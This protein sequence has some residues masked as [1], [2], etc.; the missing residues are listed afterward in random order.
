M[1]T[2]LKGFISPCALLLFG[3]L[4]CFCGPRSTAQQNKPVPV[5]IEKKDAT[6]LKGKLLGIA[7]DSVRLIDE[8]GQEWKISLKDIRNIEYQDSVRTKK[9]WFEAPNTQRYLLSSTAMPLRKNEIALQATYFILVSVHYGISNRVSVG[10]GT[11]IFTRSTY[12][13]NAKVNL[14]AQPRYKFSIG[15]NYYRLPAGSITTYSNDD[16]RN[17]GMLYGAGTWGNSSHHLTIGAGYMYTRGTILPPIVTVSGTARFARNFAF[18]TENWFFFVG[19]NNVD[20]PVL[21]SLGLRYINKRSS[22]DLA[23]YNDHEFSLETGFPYV[24]YT[25]KLGAR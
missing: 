8:N 3:L 21:L 25:F 7:R 6:V 23:F 19:S 2:Y 10:A 14:V 9:R 15:A 24:G 18:V 5:E 20:L 16:I 1:P 12:F 11:E 22:I 17:L 4:L 13:L